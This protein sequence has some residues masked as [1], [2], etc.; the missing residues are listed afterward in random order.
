MA[1]AVLEHGGLNNNLLEGDYIRCSDWIEGVARLLDKKALSDFITVLWNI[2]NI[3]NNCIFRGVEE[4]AKTTWE[5]VASLSHDY[6]IFNLPEEPC[7]RRSLRIK[8]GEN[9]HK[10]G[11][12]G[13]VDKEG[14][15]E[16]VELMALEESIYFARSKRWNKVDL[17]TD[18]VSLVNHFI[19]RDI[20]LTTFGHQTFN[21]D[22]PE[23]IHDLV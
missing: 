18:Y 6:R 5:R 8:Y 3:R 9:L 11:R 16:W 20:D 12:M 21:M 7:Y 15:S 13:V 17:K 10:S 23:D 4:V 2:W 22:Y 14:R 19:N 1:R